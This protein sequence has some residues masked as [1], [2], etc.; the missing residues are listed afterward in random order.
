MYHCFIELGYDEGKYFCDKF[1]EAYMINKI[2]YDN[3]INSLNYEL[4]VPFNIEGS[5]I[6]LGFFTQLLPK[7]HYLL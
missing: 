2:I 5:I 4:F 3:K 6:P 7:N 1:S